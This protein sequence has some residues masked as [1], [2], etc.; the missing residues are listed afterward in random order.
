MEK[1]VFLYVTGG[2]Y[3]ALNFSQDFKEQEFYER[4]VALGVDHTIVDNEDYYFEVY[5]KE[6][7][8]VDD[9]FIK[10][11]K[12]TIM[13]YDHSKDSDFFEIKPIS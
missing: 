7:G 4:M 13:D 11:I 6:F 2:D 10:F 9:K 3:S 1:R 5:I 12:N 8:P